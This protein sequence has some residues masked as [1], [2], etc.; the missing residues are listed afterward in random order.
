M[1]FI[2]AQT[3]TTCVVSEKIKGQNDISPDTE[4]QF[5]NKKERK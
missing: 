4:V 3:K 2:I 1:T 5:F